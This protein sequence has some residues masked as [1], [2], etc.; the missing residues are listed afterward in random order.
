M[1][2]TLDLVKLFNNRLEINNQKYQNNATILEGYY[3]NNTKVLDVIV[4]MISRK[5]IKYL[6]QVLIEV[7]FLKYLSKFKT[8][9]QYITL[10]YGIK[11]TPKHL[12]IILERPKGITLTQ[13]MNTVQFK[14]WNEYYNFIKVIMFRLLLAIDYIHNKDV[15]HR[16]I[17]PETIYVNY[18]DGLIQDFK[19]T[20]FA[21]SCGNYEYNV[22]E[23]D[24]VKGVRKTKKKSRVYNKLCQTISLDISPPENFKISSLLTKIKQLA[25]DQTRESMYLYLAKKM[26]IWMMGIIF[27]QLLNL[28]TLN[29]NPFNL[30]FP[31]NYE[32]NQSWK[33]YN[34]NDSAFSGVPKLLYEIVIN[35]MLS[36]IPTRGKCDEILEEFITLNKYVGDNNN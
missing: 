11:I 12:I 14:D 7:G 29:T 25:K 34:G 31:K 9:I 24:S 2:E 27:W 23:K 1:S 20:D 36:E 15:A 33:N 28:K 13:L 4:K 8:S 30:R 19:I 21:V 32:I 17:T 35:L 10:C 3:N 5:D 26:D 16:N 6:E 22:L 18:V